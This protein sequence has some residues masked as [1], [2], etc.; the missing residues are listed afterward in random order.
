MFT[1]SFPA[2]HYTDL[3]EKSNRKHEIEFLIF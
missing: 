1:P 2:F 3:G